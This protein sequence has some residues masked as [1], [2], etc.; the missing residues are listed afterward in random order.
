MIHFVRI[1]AWTM[2]SLKGNRYIKIQVIWK[3]VKPKG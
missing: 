2:K 1:V 3:E